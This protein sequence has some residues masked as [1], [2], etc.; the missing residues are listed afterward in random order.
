MKLTIA[1]LSIPERL[2]MLQKL[3]NELVHQSFNKPVEILYIG[4]NMSMTVGDKRNIALDS[5]KGEYIA[6]VD[7]DDMISEDYI[8]S[9][10]EAIET[11]PDVITFRV[12]QLYNGKKDR[13]Q[14]FERV[15]RRILDP[16]LRRKYGSPV[17]TMPPNHLCCWRRNVIDQRFPSKNKGEDHAWAERMYNNDLKIHEIDK[18]LYVYQYDSKISRTQTR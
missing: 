11:S 8:D 15:H 5:F 18:E 17:L 9:L 13:K 12:D 10:L 2:H 16:T 14:V 6:F 1:I 4:D 3:L 7:D